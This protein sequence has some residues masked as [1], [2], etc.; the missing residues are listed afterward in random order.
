[1]RKEGSESELAGSTYIKGCH[2]CTPSSC[3]ITLQQKNISPPAPPSLTLTCLQS[4]A[5]TLICY[6]LCIVS[7]AA[8]THAKKRNVPLTIW[9]FATPP[10]LAH[11][12]TQR[13]EMYFV[14]PIPK[15]CANGSCHQGSWF[16]HTSCVYDLTLIVRLSWDGLSALLHFSSHQ[17][18]ESSTTICDH[19]TTAATPRLPFI[20]AAGKYAQVCAKV[21]QCSSILHSYLSPFEHSLILPNACNLCLFFGMLWFC[22]SAWDL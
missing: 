14:P 11:A 2:V 8:P 20:C 13:K 17:K 21:S 16:L 3:G 5:I 18:E 4:L 7:L 6:Q 10:H 15:H 22:P 9:G 12:H 1:M 19:A